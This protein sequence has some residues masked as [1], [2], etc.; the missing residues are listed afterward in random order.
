MPICVIISLRLFLLPCAKSFHALL[1]S[2]KVSTVTIFSVSWLP[3][4]I[5]VDWAQICFKDKIGYCLENFKSNKKLKTFSWAGSK[6][7]KSISI[8]PCIWVCIIAS[9][10]FIA[11]KGSVSTRINCH[12]R[13]FFLRVGTGTGNQKECKWSYLWNV[14]KWCSKVCRSGQSQNL[15]LPDIETGKNERSWMHEVHKQLCKQITNS[16]HG[17]VANHGCQHKR[18][19]W[20]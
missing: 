10:Q 11:L 14:L 17:T 8:I 2:S 7:L 15:S 12:F 13:R 6:V 4:C 16:Q 5:P 9:R 20:K 19:E 18:F 1:S 3:G